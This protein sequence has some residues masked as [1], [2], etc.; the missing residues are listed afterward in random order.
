[1]NFKVLSSGRQLGFL[2]FI[3]PAFLQLFLKVLIV[4]GQLDNY[5]K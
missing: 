5:N 3:L 4:N 2:Q 1:M